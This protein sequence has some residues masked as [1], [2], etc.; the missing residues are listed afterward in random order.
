MH[1]V[2]S[3]DKNTRLIYAAG[4][5]LLLTGCMLTVFG[6]HWGVHPL[7]DAARALCLA[8]AIGLLS[9]VL[10]RKRR[11]ARAQKP[12]GDRLN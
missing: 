9:L 10:L 6:D 2:R 12:A 1:G 11:A 4:C 8:L 3:F 5:V 7:L